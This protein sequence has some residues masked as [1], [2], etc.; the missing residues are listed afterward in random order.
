LYCDS[1]VIRRGV[2]GSK[3]LFQSDGVGNTMPPPT[4]AAAMQNI[5]IYEAL[6]Q[7]FAAEG[8]LLPR[9]DVR[10]P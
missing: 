4:K 10:P 6:A 2:N 7:A 8:A 5:P 9:Q 1:L 3:V